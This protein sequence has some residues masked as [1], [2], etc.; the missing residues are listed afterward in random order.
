MNG[1]GQLVLENGLV[2]AISQALKENVDLA[3]HLN[4]VYTYVPLDLAP[5]YL[6]V[7]LDA[8]PQDPY[9]EGISYAHL[10]V[11]L[12]TR[13]RGQLEGEVLLTQIMKTLTHPLRHQ[14]DQG[15][16]VTYVLWYQDKAVLFEKDDITQRTKINFTVKEIVKKKEI[17]NDH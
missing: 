16:Q 11:E 15:D 8:L 17:F 7:A 5:P 1:G 6:K 3:E 13:Y 12:V 2:P 10:R 14:N 9:Q 4:G